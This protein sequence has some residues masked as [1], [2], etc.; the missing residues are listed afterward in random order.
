MTSENS[1]KLLQCPAQHHIAVLFSCL[2]STA[3]TGKTNE[4][5]RRRSAAVRLCDAKED[6][7]PAFAALPF[8]YLTMLDELPA[9]AASLKAKST[10]TRVNEY[11]RHCEVFC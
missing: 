11:H 9:F 5:A 2:I 1:A 6:E 4:I 3:M 8:A 10:R 7:L